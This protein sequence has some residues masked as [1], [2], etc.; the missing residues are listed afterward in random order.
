MLAESVRIFLNYALYC[1]TMEKLNLFEQE[2][3]K[4]LSK[5]S[6]PHLSDISGIAKWNKDYPDKKV[7]LTTKEG[8]IFLFVMAMLYN[9]GGGGKGR[10][11]QLLKLYP[12]IY[13]ENFKT[14]QEFLRLNQILQN[15][16]LSILDFLDIKLAYKDDYLKR[17]WDSVKKLNNDSIERAAIN[18]LIDIQTVKFDSGRKRKDESSVMQH[19]FTSKAFLIA[20]ELHANNIWPDFPLKY[21]FVPD[22]KMVQ[23][24]ARKK[25]KSEW[26]H[27]FLVSEFLYNELYS[28]EKPN[29]Y[30][31]PLLEQQ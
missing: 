30:D 1:S 18:I 28:E 19:A 29:C 25:F 27:Y 2:I 13:R 5:H 7:D 14:T 31:W 3:D 9:Y 10:H 4:Y 15:Q 22:I 23:T 20:R 8:A 6:A 11:S 16:I 21:C 24:L 17:W 26:L 12:V